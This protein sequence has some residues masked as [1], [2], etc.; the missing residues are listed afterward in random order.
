MMVLL[1]PTFTI[2]GLEPEIV[3]DTCTMRGVLSPTAATS[4]AKVVTVTVWPPTP[5]LVPLRPA[6][7][8]VAKPIRPGALPP[9]E[10][11]LPVPELDDEELVLDELLEEELE[12][13]ELEELDEDDEEL[14]ELDD[15]LDD[16]DEDDELLELDDEL[17]VPA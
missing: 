1:E 10:V 11:E 4:C 16:E 12:E 3:P 5:P 8:S 15:E 7:F 14:L 17:V 13:E 9:D 6:L 2:F